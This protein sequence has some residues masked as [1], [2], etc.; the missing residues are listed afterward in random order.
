MSNTS[1]TQKIR[2]IIRDEK[3]SWA[4]KGLGCHLASFNAKVRFANTIFDGTF[5]ALQELQK[6]NYLEIEEANY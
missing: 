1:G 2:R 6:N 5:D 4:A 3:L